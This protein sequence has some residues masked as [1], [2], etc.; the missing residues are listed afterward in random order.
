VK[1]L[2]ILVV[3][4]GAMGS[5]LSALLWR[6]GEN[7]ELLSRR[8]IKNIEVTGVE[9]FIAEPKIVTR[10][11]G[12]YE[13]IILAVKSYSTREVLE[14]IRGHIKNAWLLSLQ[15]G[16]GN[17][18]LAMRYTQKVLG[19]ITTNGAEVLEAGKV[20]W[21]GKGIIVLG[22]YPYGRNRMAKK[23]VEVF[24]RAGIEAGITENA[25]GWKWA[26]TIVNSVINGIGTVMR[27]KNG[28]L[29]EIPEL[30]AISVE[31]AREGCNVAQRLDI[32]FEVHPL[33]LLWETIE[34]TKE[35]Y[36]ST[37]QDIRRGKR[38]EVDYIHGKIVEYAS[39]MGLEAP[40]NELLWAMI[41]GMERLGVE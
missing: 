1:V 39:S 27:V 14:E 10:A 2:R 11:E 29:M 32:E 38:T 20:R 31:V 19:G 12:E 37:L 36:N 21:V 22:S 26:K 16:L 40:R 7:V 34:R 35:N 3:G 41:K 25:I 28:T 23:V 15:N 6:E 13:L 4:A 8:R 30:E 9:N 17:E 24:K 33:E 18:E 5:L